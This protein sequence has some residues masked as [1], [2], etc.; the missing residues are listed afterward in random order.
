MITIRLHCLLPIYLSEPSLICDFCPSDRVFAYNFLQILP[1]CKHPCCSAMHFPLS[2][3]A[4]DSHPLEFAH[5]GRTT[6]K[7]LVKTSLFPKLESFRKG[8]P[9]SSFKVYFIICTNNILL[10]LYFI[11]IVPIFSILCRS[12]A[13]VFTKHFSKIT[14]V[15]KTTIVRNLCNRFCCFCQHCTCFS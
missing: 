3:H 5:V 13:K 6:K 15:A 1:H 10:V 14:A 2:G 9:I 12:T 8:I 11:T 4:R 7:R